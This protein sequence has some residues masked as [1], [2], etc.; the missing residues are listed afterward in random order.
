[1]ASVLVL[2]YYVLELRTI[3]LGSLLLQRAVSA[4]C[5]SYQST[6]TIIFLDTVAIRFL[7]SFALIR[8]T[9]VDSD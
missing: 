3:H 2:F 6:V 5:Y 9:Y 4:E 8:R 7:D 1:M